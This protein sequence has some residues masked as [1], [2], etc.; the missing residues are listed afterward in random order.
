MD[1]YAK[2]W[3]K[4]AVNGMIVSK[5]FLLEDKDIIELHI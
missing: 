1:Q 2:L 3:R 5:E 4:D